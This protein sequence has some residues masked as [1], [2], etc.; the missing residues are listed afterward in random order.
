M[1]HNALEKSVIGKLMI[2]IGLFVAAPLVILPWYPQEIK[3]FWEFMIPGGGSVLLGVLLCIVKSKPGPQSV[4]WKSSMGRSSL[5]VLFAWSWAVIVG[6]IPFV[7]GNQLTVVQALF[8][9]VSG[10]TTTGLSAIDVTKTTPIYLFHR[11][12]MQYCGG[13]G[14]IM[15]MI[16]FISNKHA[17]NL[18]SAE[19]HPDKIMPNIKKTAQ[20]IFIIY[21][22]CLVLG[23]VAYRIAGMTWF[24]SICHCMCSLS[25]GGFSTK[26]RSIG[27]Y[28]SLPIEIITIVLM[29][30]G[31]TNFAALILLATGKFKAF[32]R[33]SEVRFMFLVL[34]ILIPPTAFSLAHGLNVSLGE[35]FRKASFDIVSAMSTSGYSTM[36]YAQWPQFA[37]GVLIIAMIMGGGIGSTAGGIKLSRVYIM[38][39]LV[40]LHIQ[41]RLN[42]SRSVR[43]PHYWRA[44]IKEP[45]DEELSEDTTAFFMSYLILLVI[46]TFA[47]SVAADCTLTEALFDMSSSLS[48]VGLSIGITGPTTGNAA[49]IIE[50]I[51][52][53]LGRL[54]IFI[55]LIGITFGFGM[56]K[57][58]I[59]QCFSRITNCLRA[60]K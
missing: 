60:H 56:L 14:F 6:A 21:N 22:V 11:S 50:M 44:N 28:N 41:K 37:I 47:L 35:G 53:F 10:W 36:S 13:L 54:E 17:M 33:V 48:T 31:T 20:A 39:R 26:L 45:I 42:P 46:G 19:G 9:A 49:L 43:A 58:R 25:T 2:L 27:E 40:G 29:L 30:I 59:R 12:F 57:S 4:G 55:V 23:S 32:F 51:G 1:K 24:D 34:L 38:F 5:T 16:L 18:Y 15:V 3:F 52:M 7:L 8:E